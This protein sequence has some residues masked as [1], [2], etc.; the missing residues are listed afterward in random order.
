MAEASSG[1]TSLDFASKS[2]FRP[3]DHDQ[4]RRGGGHSRNI[5]TSPEA[6]D[7]DSDESFQCRG[8]HSK[9]A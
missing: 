6:V 5:S 7:S 2:Q 8:L 1:S 4:V 3:P 9:L